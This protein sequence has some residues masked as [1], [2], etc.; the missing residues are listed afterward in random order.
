[1]PATIDLHLHTLASDGRLSPTELIQLVANQGLETISITDHDSTEGLAEAYEAAKKFPYMRIIPGIEMSADI[2]GDEVHV[3]GYFLDYHDVEFQEMLT[4][5]RRGR[6]GRA[7]VMVEKL[8]ALGKPVEW[9]RV[10]HFAGDGTVGRPHI[11]LAMVEAGYFKEPKEAFE[12]YLGNDGLAYYDRPKLNPT[13]SVAMIRKV[14]GV[15]VLAHPT[16]MNDMEAGI[17]S[18]KKEGLVGMEVYYAQYDDDTVRHLARLAR[19]YDLIPCG[20]S[21]YHGLGNTGEPLPGT[22]GPPEETVKLL[23]DAAAVT[24]AAQDKSN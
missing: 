22:L 21:D 14:G 7:Q 6:V 15:P 12:E 20:G 19:E 4:E 5:L 2:P 17:A 3:L 16:F 11:A 24:K 18:L 13:E 1:M 9:E 23:E 10:L 8:V